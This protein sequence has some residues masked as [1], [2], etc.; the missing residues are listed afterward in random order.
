MHCTIASRKTAAV[1]R[2]LYPT[3]EPS[4]AHKQAVRHITR[5]TIR[6]FEFLTEAARFADAQAEAIVRRGND[7][8]S[9]NR[10]RRNLD[11][12]WE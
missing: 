12:R 3:E 5:S 6:K 1:P 2:I 8:K 10:G 9:R 7:K 4:N 11:R